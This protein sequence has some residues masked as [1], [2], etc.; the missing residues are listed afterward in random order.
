MSVLI[1]PRRVDAVLFDLD[2]GLDAT[3]ASRLRDAG[4][5]L[6]SADGAALA[7]TAGAL[8]VRP[9]RCAVVTTTEQGVTDARA[10]GFALVI[11]VDPAG[12]LRSRDADAVVAN[13]NDVDVRGGDRRMSE[14]P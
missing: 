10:G 6:V 7:E 5:R 4:V 1:D 2:D 8:G 3:F 14:L 12:D 11:A 9:G 13:V